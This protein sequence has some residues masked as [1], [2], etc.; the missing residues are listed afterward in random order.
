[1]DRDT[2]CSTKTSM[3]GKYDGSQTGHLKNKNHDGVLAPYVYDF[4]LENVGK[5]SPQYISIDEGSVRRFLLDLRVQATC[6]KPLECQDTAWRAHSMMR[7]TVSR[8]SEANLAAY[9]EGR[10]IGNSSC[11]EISN[12]I[13]RICV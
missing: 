2:Q 11:K 12:Q 5:Y 8:Y 10:R 1:M 9:R 3:R 6:G 4:D 13:C 7:K